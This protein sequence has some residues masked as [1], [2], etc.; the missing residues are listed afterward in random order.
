MAGSSSYRS[1]PSR[2]RRLLG[3]PAGRAFADDERERGRLALTL[4][5]EFEEQGTGWFWQTDRDGRVTYLSPLVAERIGDG[6]DDVLGRALVELFQTDERWS[7]NT[8]T[9]AFHLS[10]QTAFADLPIHA[11]TGDTDRAWAITGRPRLD[12][13]GHFI[14]FVGTGS[15][16]TEKRRSQ[17][18]I[19]NLAMYDALT[20]L[21]N[22][23]RMKMALEDTLR[24]SRTSYRSSS[25]LLLDLDRFKAVNDTL[26]HQTGDLLLQQ[27]GQRLQRVVA[28]AGLVGRLGGDEFQVLVAGEA[29]RERLADLAADIIATLSQPY[30]LSG[31]SV[32]IGCSVGIAVAP[33]DGD[34]VDTLVRSADLA[35][36][37][38]KADGRG[39]HRFYRP[40]MLA[41][42]Q[43]RKQLEEDLR[44]ALAQDE[45]H[46]A[47]Q[48]LVSTG[49]EARIVGYEALL[50][51]DHPIRGAISPAD[52][53]PVAEECGLIEMLG[54]WVLR[55][56]TREAA[57][58]PGDVRVAVNVSAIQFAN[59]ALPAIVTSALASSGIAA[60]RLELEI[61]ES[62][63]LTDSAACEGMFAR[64]KT[65]GVR[66]ALDDFG[67]GYSSLGYLKSAPFD[68]IKIDQ[69]F[70]RGAIV[71]GSRNGAII[72]AIVTLAA[73]LGMDTTAEGVEA[74]DEIDLIRD[75]GCTHIQGY[76]YG[77]PM[78]AEQVRAQLAE[79]GGLAV[80][81]G[82]RVTRAL[83]VKTLRWAK[84]V[85]GSESGPVRI[86]NVSASGALIDGIELPDATVGSRVMIE[87]MDE[88]LFPARVRWA[89]NGYAGLA[90][91]SKFDLE[92]LGPA[93]KR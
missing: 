34:T 70:V 89:K 78:R 27:V 57:T 19:T 41:G 91:D 38:A 71:P 26:G 4:V 87:L 18:E 29:K 84:L 36:Y 23:Q 83:R 30:F 28:D 7:Q 63:F 40:E 3:E 35:L 50:R 74:Q 10:S 65:L 85:I 11:V 52:F 79:H 59:P 46:V 44:A 39:V 82:H 55:T 32:S 17:A 45:L 15:D 88:Q 25:L 51:W 33:E 67:T 37:A 20:G 92:R 58:W 54:E 62:V 61:T 66:L 47:Y 16:L 69:S 2:L 43:S 80:P 1:V 24:Q 56:A 76:V 22:R 60:G 31:S 9:L 42:A 75:L 68:K 77:R 53:V 13:L 21:P 86:R 6:A 12:P 8:R 93:K 72:H 81:V 5:R 64:L 73:T 14:G 49:V 90:F 48:P